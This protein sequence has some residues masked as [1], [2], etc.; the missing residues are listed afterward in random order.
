VAV[1]AT[2]RQAASR[3][4]GD[5]SRVLV[6][7]GDVRQAVHEQRS[8]SLI[9]LA[10][11]ASGSMGAAQR[12]EAAK[13]A[14]IALLRD[15]YQRRDQVALVAF[16]GER[17]DVLLRPTGSVEVARARLAELPTGGRTPLAA[18]LQA[19]LD[20]AVSPARSVGHR[21]LLVLITDGRATSGPDGREPF[22]A[23]L[24]VCAQ[25]R[26]SAVPAVVIDA[27]PAGGPRLGLAA[28]LGAAMGAECVSLAELS[29]T[30][31]EQAVRR[32]ALN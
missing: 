16:R 26:R 18:G 32:A 30:A 17:A 13:G 24:A 15:A 14:A 27:E 4:A 28:R 5:G 19:A 22:E 7:A 3:R 11:D 9:V 1:G 21:P 2:V 6:D 31:V 23:A 10:V 20:L 29:A 12:M 25:V 8:A